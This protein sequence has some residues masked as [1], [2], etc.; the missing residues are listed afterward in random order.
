VTA[1]LG[2]APLRDHADMS[3]PVLV[4]A[5]DGVDAF[6]SVDDAAASMEGIDVDNGEY[7]A[8]FTLDGRIVTATA[9]RNDVV[10]TIT[11]RRDEPD[12]DRRLREW[13]PR[14]G[15]TSPPDDRRAIANELMRL[16]WELRWPKRPRWLARRLHGAAPPQI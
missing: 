11:D 13:A 10:L 9:S 12:L 3:A 7:P 14:I 5:L 8:L 6:P 15:L 2:A 16:D 1:G 4:F